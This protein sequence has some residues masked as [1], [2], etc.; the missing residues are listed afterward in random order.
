[1]YCVLGADWVN[2][3][4]TQFAYKSRTHAHEVSGSCADFVSIFGT[5]ITD[6]F[7]GGANDVRGALLLIVSEESPRRSLTPITF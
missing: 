7:C 3:H 1:M 2:R 4:E 5:D 6:T